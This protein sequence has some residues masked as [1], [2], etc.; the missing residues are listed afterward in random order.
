MYDSRNISNRSRKYKYIF[1]VLVYRNTEDI[2]DMLTSV[3]QQVNNYKVLIVN[4]Y[5][6]NESKKAFEKIAKDHK[7]DFINVENKGYGYGNNAGIRYAMNNYSFEYIVVS[8]PDITI[9]RF[10]DSQISNLSD[11]PIGPMITARD[12]KSQNPYWAIENQLCEYFIYRG[13]KNKSQW[14]LL[15]GIVINKII[16]EAFLLV[17]R[18]LPIINVRVYALHGSFIIYPKTFLDRITMPLYDEKIFLFSEEADLAHD[19]KSL[20]I[21]STL[22]KSINIKHKEDGS[23][24]IAKIEEKSELR[25][26][27]IYY[28]EKHHCRHNNV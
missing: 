23:M 7:C 5:Y 18:I 17:F 10:D 11:G 13:Y 6:D 25:K 22:T 24:G 21:K 4:S 20:Q 14:L 8:N 3:H 12:N 9:R 15:L 28:Y 19:L 27:V 26:S 2:L 1:V 16:R